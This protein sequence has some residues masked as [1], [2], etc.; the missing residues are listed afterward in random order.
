MSLI[1]QSSALAEA[2]PESLSELM[3]RDPEGYQ[4]QDRQRII[5]ALR[6]QREKWAAGEGSKP[7]KAIKAAAGLLQKSV[8]TAEEL[9]F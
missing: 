9:G 6:A 3:S 8:K 4:R 1:P 7:P 2:S 5:E